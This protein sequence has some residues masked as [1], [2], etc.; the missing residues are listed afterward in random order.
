[1]AAF[2]K[3]DNKARA[4]DFFNMMMAPETKPS[5]EPPPG[6]PAE[7]AP[8]PAPDAEAGPAEPA[9]VDAAAGTLPGPAA[10]P[11]P[12]PKRHVPPGSDE[13]ASG[14]GSARTRPGE[15]GRPDR[16]DRP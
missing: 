14:P 5:P 16:A 2:R 8:E 12:I 4:S 3:Q 10:L 6:A 13:I 7:A 9:L 15:R 1:M 11:P